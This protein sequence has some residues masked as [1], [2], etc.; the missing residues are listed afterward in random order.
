MKNDGQDGGRRPLKIQEKTRK[1]GARWNGRTKED[2][3][4][5]RKWFIWIIGLWITAIKFTTM[6]TFP[7]FS[8]ND[9]RAVQEPS[10]AFNLFLIEI[11]P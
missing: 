1:M 6:L 11:H 4:S 10:A 9:S 7:N 2:G 8:V 3:Y 5:F